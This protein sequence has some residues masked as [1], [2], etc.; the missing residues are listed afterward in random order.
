MKDKKCH[1]LQPGYVLSALPE[2]WEG[3]VTCAFCD[4]LVRVPDPRKPRQPDQELLD[5]KLTEWK[6][7]EDE[8]NRVCTCGGKPTKDGLRCSVCGGKILQAEPAPIQLP[9]K[10]S[11]EERLAAVEMR[12]DKLDDVPLSR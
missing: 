5:R 9:R 12:L 1:C 6:K 7:E 8:K 2:N 10:L 3:T 4:G 11:V